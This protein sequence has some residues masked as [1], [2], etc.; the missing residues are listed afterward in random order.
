MTGNNGPIDYSN[1]EEN[2]NATHTSQN[3]YSVPYIAQET[4]FDF[5]YSEN[6]QVVEEETQVSNDAGDPVRLETGE[7]EYSN[8]LMTTLSA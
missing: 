7:F 4:N 3:T 8:T 1:P 2:N 5:T 6:E